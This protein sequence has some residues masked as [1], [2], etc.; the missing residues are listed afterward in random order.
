MIT[1][2]TIGVADI[3]RSLAF[4]DPVLA[5]L[6]YERAFHQG[7]WA[8]YQPKDRPDQMAVFLCKPFD[9]EPARAG[10]G[11]MVGLTAQSS[12]DVDAFHAAALANGGSDEGAPGPRPPEGKEN[13]LAYVRDPVGNKL[14]A[15]Y[16]TPHAP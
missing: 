9:G 11:I 16:R 7:D 6:G 2:V 14:A 4:Y 5:A 1:Y 13:Y 15:M 3:D 10:N 12:A 8:G